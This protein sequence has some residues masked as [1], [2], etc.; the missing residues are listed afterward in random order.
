[1]NKAGVVVMAVLAVA[2]VAIPPSAVVRIGF[3]VPPGSAVAAAEVDLSFRIDSATAS[4]QDSVVQRLH[5]RNG[6]TA[7]DGRLAVTYVTAMYVN[8]D[9]AQ[10][11]PDGCGMRLAD[12][13]PTV[14]EVVT[15]RRQVRLE[16]EQEVTLD[17][18]LTV[19]SD[20][21]FAGRTLG[22]AMAAPPAD[23]GV[24]DANL[25][26]NWEYGQLR[27]LPPTPPTPSGSPM[28]LYLTH[29]V[30]ALAK[31]KPTTAD[32]HYS[33]KA[34]GRAAGGV[35]FTFVTPFYVNHHGILPPGC[36]MRL[37]DSDPL[38]PEIVT[39]S[40]PPLPPG[41][42]RSLSIPL[43][44]VQDAPHGQVGGLALVAPAADGRFAGVETW[45]IDN[46]LPVT[47]VNISAP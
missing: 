13:D 29:D 44:L 3:A 21:R 14:P 47:T 4:S 40:L 16:P 36:G 41:A 8:I 23:S 39:C 19:T 31:N 26:D 15:C 22:L 18:P 17:M 2:A 9:R 7:Y 38:V 37:T 6:D 10:P 34:P 28:D 32:F 20:A 46:F 24:V 33:R 1:M 42:T 45:Q 35:R 30:P 5:V 25:S 27:L 43:T 12:T 11:L